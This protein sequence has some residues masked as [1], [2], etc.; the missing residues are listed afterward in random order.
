M[1]AKCFQCTVRPAGN[2]YAGPYSAYCGE[3]QP[4]DMRPQLRGP[5]CRCGH[6]LCT[7]ANL[8]TFDKHRRNFECR[9]PESMGLEI[10][11]GIWGTPEGNANRDRMVVRLA[12]AAGRSAQ[13]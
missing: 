5:K 7:F 10:R 9:T 12:A 2:E 11:A 4:H 3:C 13:G 8:G 1:A 6:C